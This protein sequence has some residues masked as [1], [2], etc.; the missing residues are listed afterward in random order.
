MLPKK[1]KKIYQVF[2]K[3]KFHYH[4]FLLEKMAHYT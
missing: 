1:L 4:S 2:L 3:L